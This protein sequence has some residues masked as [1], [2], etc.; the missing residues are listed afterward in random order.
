MR[1]P[2]ATQQC[3]PLWWLLPSWLWHPTDQFV[4]FIRFRCFRSQLHQPLRNPPGTANLVS[5]WIDQRGRPIVTASSDHYFYT[6][7]L[8]V[9][10]SL[11]F[12]KL[13]QTKQSSSENSDRYWRDCGSDRGDHWWQACLK[14]RVLHV[15]YFFWHHSTFNYMMLFSKVPSTTRQWFL[16][17]HCTAWPALHL[18]IRRCPSRVLRQCRHLSCPAPQQRQ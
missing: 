14:V 18:L 1:F 8:Y 16:W 13:R 10:P 11:T 6:W 4:R 12:S 2:W 17:R 3:L 15:L 7:Y 9:S 5:L